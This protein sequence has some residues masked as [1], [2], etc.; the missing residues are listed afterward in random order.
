MKIGT[1]TKF[2]STFNFSKI[3]GIIIVKITNIIS[4]IIALFFILS[5]FVPIITPPKI[6]KAINP[7]AIRLFPFLET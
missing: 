7:P 4:V 6:A 3:I 5:K 2:N 1:I